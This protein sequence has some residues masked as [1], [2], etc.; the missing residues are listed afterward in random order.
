M[1]LASAQLSIVQ[2]TVLGLQPLPVISALNAPVG[3]NTL[4]FSCATL[5]MAKATDEVGTSTMASTPSSSNQR[6]AIAEPTSGLFWWSAMTI[7]IWHASHLRLHALG[8]HPGCKD[9][10]LAEDIGIDAGHVAQHADFQRA[11]GHVGPGS[12]RR[13]ERRRDRGGQ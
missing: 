8:C 4:S 3:M 7:S 1:L 10:A 13:G 5:A 12:G 2:C 9:R 6:R 11:L